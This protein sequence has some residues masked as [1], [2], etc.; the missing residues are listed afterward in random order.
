MKLNVVAR[1]HKLYFMIISEKKWRIYYIF[2]L[3]WSLKY[4]FM[5]QNPTLEETKISKH[6]NK[7]GIRYDCHGQYRHEMVKA[8]RR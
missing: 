4:P 5:L 1:S 6:I 2:P 3:P 8:V 7:I